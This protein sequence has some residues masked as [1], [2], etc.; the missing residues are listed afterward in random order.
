MCLMI[1]RDGL[2]KS[3]LD[4]NKSCVGIIVRK[5]LY[6]Y[7][8]IYIYIHGISKKYIIWDIK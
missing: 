3:Q 8:Y 7:I 5:E 4:E 1:V 6:I 2:F